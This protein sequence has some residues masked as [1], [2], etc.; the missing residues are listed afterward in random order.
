VTGSALA[1]Q[2]GQRPVAG[3]F[4]LPVGHVRTVG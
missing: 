3:S 4:E 2:E 1:R